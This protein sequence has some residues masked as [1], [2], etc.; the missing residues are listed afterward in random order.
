M[1][2]EDCGGDPR[3]TVTAC[4]WTGAGANKLLATTTVAASVAGLNHLRTAMIGSIDFQSSI[5][6]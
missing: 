3:K 2:E 5:L 6:K 1:D 4:A